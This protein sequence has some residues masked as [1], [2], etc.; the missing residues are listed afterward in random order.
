MH[1]PTTTATATLLVTV[2]VS[3][4]TGCVTTHHPPPHPSSPVPS[5]PSEP[6]PD[7]TR[8]T[9]IVQAP[10]REALELIGPPRSPAPSTSTAPRS[11][12]PTATVAA[13]DPVGPVPAPSSRHKR[14]GPHQRYGPPPGS[15]PSIDIPPL[16]E[17][18]PTQP[19][20]NSDVCALGH[21]YGGWGRDTPQAAICK[22]V[23]GR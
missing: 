13:P 21:R 15:R 10:A 14:Q 5:P 2:A 7:G 3:A 22:D 9:Q 18:I 23:Y 1:R 12:V 17:N 11:T 19:P 20:G 6:R 16:P 4:L 8:E